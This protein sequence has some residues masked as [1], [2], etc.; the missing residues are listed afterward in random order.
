MVSPLILLPFILLIVFFVGGLSFAIAGR[1]N[2]AAWIPLLLAEVVGWG[3]VAR[4]LSSL[5]AGA[6]PAWAPRWQLL[7]IFWILC[8]PL[9]LCVSAWLFNRYRER[10]LRR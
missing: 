4:A 6:E 5:V 10:A 1:R 8:L 2:R 3:L 7:R 9:F